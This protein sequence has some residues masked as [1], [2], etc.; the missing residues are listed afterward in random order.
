MGWNLDPTI[1]LDPVNECF[2]EGSRMLVG[3]ELM[4]KVPNFEQILDELRESK[5]MEEDMQTGEAMQLTHEE[6]AAKYGPNAYLFP[7]VR[8]GSR[9]TLR[10]PLG[11]VPA[12][13]NVEEAAQRASGKKAY[14]KYVLNPQDRV[15]YLQWQKDNKPMPNEVEQE[16]ESLPAKLLN[17]GS[18]IIHS[19][20]G[21][22]KGMG[23]KLADVGIP[24]PGTSK[25]PDDSQPNGH[26]PYP[27]VLK[28][29]EDTVHD[30]ETVS[31]K[32]LEDGD[33]IVIFSHQQGG[34][35]SK[36]Q[37]NLFAKS[38]RGYQAIQERGVL[39][40]KV[41]EALG[42]SSEQAQELVQDERSVYGPNGVDH[43]IL[44]TLSQRDPAVPKRRTLV[45]N[46][47][48]LIPDQQP[49]SAPIRT[50]RP[51]RRGGQSAP[52]SQ[53]N[54]PVEAP[55]TPVANTRGNRP[56]GKV[57]VLPQPAAPVATPAASPP[58]YNRFDAAEFA[59]STPERKVPADWQPFD[60]VEV[61]DQQDAV[62]VLRQHASFLS[63]RD[64]AALV[65]FGTIMGSLKGTDVYQQVQLPEGA[66][67]VS[68]DDQIAQ[69]ALMTLARRRSDLEAQ[70]LDLIIVASRK[71]RRYPHLTWDEWQQLEWLSRQSPDTETNPEPQGQTKAPS[72]ISKAANST[73]ETWRTMRAPK[74]D[75]L[76]VIDSVSPEEDPTV[77]AILNGVADMMNKKEEDRVND[78]LKLV[79]ISII[80]TVGAVIVLL[81]LTAFGAL[82]FAF[83]GIIMVAIPF[84]VLCLLVGYLWQKQ[85]H[86]KVTMR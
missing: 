28:P 86:R 31:Y 8:K 39:E 40:I 1:R 58:P 48:N 13:Y 34:N 81:I 17:M 76:L 83:E 50:L 29:E 36:N 53:A 56:L 47:E 59:P 37:A 33:N 15:A 52:E 5:Q 78:G 41:D 79:V 7:E 64:T 35:L 38:A 11:N 70:V 14:D 3:E 20:S 43:L 74:K 69:E 65:T 21:G 30:P 67:I 12:S 62:R 51:M 71:D 46:N 82:N 63:D 80:A 16:T 84:Y 60:E 10:W 66:L 4:Q 77:L 55:V 72:F 6:F 73:K 27:S 2:L 42:V 9:N 44:H 32:V 54:T 22:I 18:D 23:Q 85:D 49:P 24:V 19:A 61:W 25:A 26:H 57:E 75:E 45:T 68:N